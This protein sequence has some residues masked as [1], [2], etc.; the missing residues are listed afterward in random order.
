MARE[1]SLNAASSAERSER[2]FDAKAPPPYPRRVLRVL[3]GSHSHRRLTM[4]WNGSLNIEDLL[5]LYEAGTLSPV[6]VV[7][8]CYE[9]IA[10]YADKAVWIELV[11]QEEAL[12]AAKAL[13]ASRPASGPLPLLV[14]RRRGMWGTLELTTRAVGRSVLRK[15][16]RGRQG[17][18]HYR[19]LCIV[20]LYTNQECPSRRP[21]AGSGRTPHRLHQPRP[22]RH[23]AG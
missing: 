4:S 18:C 12:A 16:Q 20:R 9:R 19:R 1:L 17:T 2:R 6:T 23:R 7:A 14:S 5:P 22:V 15:E 21:R 8:S 3:A 10:A 13:E 11:P